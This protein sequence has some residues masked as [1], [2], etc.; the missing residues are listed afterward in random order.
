MKVGRLDDSPAA[1]QWRQI[2]GGL[3]V[4]DADD[5]PDPSKNGRSSPTPCLPMPAGSDLRFAWSLVRH[6]KVECDRTGRRAMRCAVSG[7]DR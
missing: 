6:V 7:P 1:R 3:L 5:G 4:Q 2:A